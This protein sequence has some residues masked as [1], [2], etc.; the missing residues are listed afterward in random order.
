MDDRQIYIIYEKYIHRFGDARNQ[1]LEHTVRVFELFVLEAVLVSTLSVSR[2]RIIDGPPCYNI[3]IM[4]NKLI[5]YT[6]PEV[7][8]ITN[9]KYLH[10]CHSALRRKLPGIF[11]DDHDAII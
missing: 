5:L 9:N 6:K 1:M 11:E 2:R 10:F 3:K 8:R 7:K 4:N